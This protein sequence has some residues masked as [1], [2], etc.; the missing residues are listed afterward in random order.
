MG[1]SH[2]FTGR[3]VVWLVRGLAFVLTGLL[4]TIGGIASFQLF[5]LLAVTGRPLLLLPL[6]A[7]LVWVGLVYLRRVATPGPAWSA[8]AGQCSWLALVALFLSPFAYLWHKLPWLDYL[9][10][11]V[12]LLLV[13]AAAVLSFIN[14]LVQRLAEFF[15]DETLETMARVCQGVNYLLVVFPMAG[16]LAVLSAMSWH[17]QLSFGDILREWLNSLPAWAKVFVL[18]PPCL[19]G[20]LLWT[21]KAMGLAQLGE[22]A[23][24]P[25]GAGPSENNVPQ[26][27]EASRR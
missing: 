19:T 9:G 12:L 24:R 27:V 17:Y 16:G 5:P 23:G 3:E 2:K 21:A 15:N 25:N 6:G 14:R 18:S 7:L 26:R 11:N 10:W 8:T 1:A 20:A 13:A 22:T 4:A